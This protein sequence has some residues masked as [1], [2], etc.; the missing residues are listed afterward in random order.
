MRDKDVMTTTDTPRADAYNNTLGVV[1]ADFARQLER[2]LKASQEAYLQSIERDDYLTQQLAE[3]KAEVERLKANL[4]DAIEIAEGLAIIASDEY[5]YS[6]SVDFY[7]M[8]FYG[9]EDDSELPAQGKI[10]RLE[11]KLQQL[12]AAI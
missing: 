12:K 7:K 10:G 6:S 9:T 1:P 5:G 3:A 8:Y 11:I 2:E 4:R